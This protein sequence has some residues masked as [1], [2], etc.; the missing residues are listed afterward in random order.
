MNVPKVDRSMHEQ[1][2]G[3]GISSSKLRLLGVVV[4]CAESAYYA[5]EPTLL[6]RVGRDADD[7]LCT[8]SNLRRPAVRSMRGMAGAPSP[9]APQ[10]ERGHVIAMEAV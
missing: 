2:V 5:K 6:A 10:P 4:A 9:M 1:S 7:L 8:F 3:R